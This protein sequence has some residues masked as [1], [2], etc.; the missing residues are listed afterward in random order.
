[1]VATSFAIRQSK[2]IL[3]RSCEAEKGIVGWNQERWLRKNWGALPDLA[4]LSTVLSTHG[5]F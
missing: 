3:A 1:M 2:T 4:S 5:I